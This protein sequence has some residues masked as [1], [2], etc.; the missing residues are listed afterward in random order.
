MSK[1][2]S[3]KTTT[4]KKLEFVDCLDMINTEIAKRRGKWQL[5]SISWMDYDDVAQILRF[6][7][8]RKW[9]LF[10]QTK[11]PK[12]WVRT[13]ITNQIKNLIRN[14]YSNFVKPCNR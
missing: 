6:H 2:K 14:N 11:N 7:I 12:P 8:Y 13:I 3:S 4:S 5:D 1:K 10:D 9:H